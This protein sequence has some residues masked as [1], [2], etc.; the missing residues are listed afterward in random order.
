MEDNYRSW[1]WEKLGERCVKNM[2]NHGF[3]AHFVS[4]PDEAKDL[5]LGMISGYET[6]GFGG[7]DTTRSLGIMEALKATGKTVY[8]HWQ[9]GL[10]K[11]QDLEIRLQQG[12]C[13]CFLCSANAISA[14]GE[15]INV[16]GIGNRTDAMT[17]GPKKVLIIAGMNKVTHDLES[18]LTR[19]RDV[20]GPMRAKS[21]G[22]ETPC[23][24]TGICTDCNSPQR[25]CRVTVI[26]HR[27]PMLTD[28]SV[29][30]INRS[31]GF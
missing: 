30:L 22:M 27:R 6:F 12:R 2:K 10:D 3:D 13:D 25:I 14:T 1:L 18:A 4:T 24:E 26:L 9:K 28:I 20:A 7:S 23:A 29:V 8:D 21:L 15:I 19:V 16:D 17:F 11:A 31:M 5:V